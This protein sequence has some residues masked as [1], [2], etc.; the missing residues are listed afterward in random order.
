MFGLHPL[1]LLRY[2]VAYLLALALIELTIAAIAGLFLFR[3]ADLLLLLSAIAALIALPLILS[4]LP[5]WIC[6]L[7]VQVVGA[8]ATIRFVT[9]PVA[10]SRSLTSMPSGPV[11]VDL[12]FGHAAVTLGVVNG[13]LL[14]LSLLALLTWELTWGV[15]WLTLR[16]GYVWSAI[17]MA[18][19]TLLAAANLVSGV[20]AW[21][22]P[23]SL[24]AL[25][26]V[27]WH[28]W[29]GRLMC[30][31]SQDE[32][33]Q[34]RASTSLSLLGGLAA[35]AL[36]VPAAWA[37]PS[38]SSA[39]LSRWGQQVWS[40]VGPALD[41][42]LHVLNR[43]TH[44]V[45]VSSGFGT[46]LNLNGPFRPYPGLVMTV[47]N[48]PPGLSPYWRGTI[49]D[50]F[51]D[52]TWEADGNA[53]LPVGAGDAIPADVP[54][55]LGSQIVVRI[56]VIQPGDNEL[57]APGRPVMATLA[58]RTEYAAAGSGSEPVVVYAQ[59]PLSDG[60][61][62]EVTA[63]VPAVHPY[64]GARGLPADPRY[65]ALPQGV[66]PRIVALALALTGSAKSPYAAAMSIEAYLKS[67]LF[68]YD[69]NA[70]AAPSGEDPISY[71]LFQSRRG[72]CV[73]FASAMALLARAAGLPARVVGGYASGRL[74]NGIW[75]VSGG[76]AHTWPEVFVAGTGWVPFEPTPG[77][78][79]ESTIVTR[80]DE[81]ATSAGA[82]TS[83][84]PRSAA[85]P[86]PHAT[87]RSVQARGAEGRQSWAALGVLGGLLL[88]ICCLVPALMRREAKTP[89]GIYRSM[90]RTA[91]WLAI[92]PQPSQT[93]EEFARLYAARRAAEHEDVAHI[94]ALYAAWCYGRRT[95]SSV[96]LQDAQAALKRL[97][98]SWLAHHLR[99]WRRA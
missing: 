31:A 27:L 53:V 92:R 93:P 3:G 19:G 8:A 74:Q 44:V 98:R 99:P 68:T 59:T 81:G 50:I 78:A 86:A 17:V 89:R 2:T 90:C 61:S 60:T 42:P 18:A 70:G 73:H 10:L 96:D 67:G 97:R 85:R 1:Q 72:Y 76:D 6:W 22:L 56:H 23:F 26:Q 29:S 88:A 84:R 82:G 54:R 24:V 46:R 75:Q 43:G 52:G 16:A 51:R 14:L 12:P 47:S 66:D 38:P 71:F 95:A 63:E 48:V 9:T 28:T 13:N 64:P 91:R 21:L 33:L 20:E 40:T 57:F 55:H 94:T 15:L 36:I 30:A 25:A 37:A 11:S 83:A 77:F 34:P 80:P 87:R 62:Y 4:P 58:T 49:Y 39:S 7:A 35:L 5:D 32:A 41:D 45:P 79:G 65:L 69:T